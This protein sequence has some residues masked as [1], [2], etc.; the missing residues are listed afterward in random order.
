MEWLTRITVVPPPI[1][2]CMRFSHFCWNKK[3]PTA[4]I[5][6][7][8]STS[9]FVVVATAKARRDTMPEE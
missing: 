2:S 5:S 7:A 4:R 1:S 6:S 8:I 9:G 3:S